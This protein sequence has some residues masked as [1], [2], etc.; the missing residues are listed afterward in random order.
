MIRTYFWNIDLIEYLMTHPSGYQTI[1]ISWIKVNKHI[2]T[3]DPSHYLRSSQILYSIIL[4]TNM[5]L[6]SCS[7]SL[8]SQNLRSI[9]QFFILYAIFVFLLA[10][11]SFT[12]PSITTVY[13]S[14]FKVLWHRKIGKTVF[15]EYYRR[16]IQ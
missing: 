9:I 5:F 1:F 10:S 8:I 14:V 15:I 13:G 16:Y 4:Y 12:S 6:Y 2:F 11:Y 3:P 7:K